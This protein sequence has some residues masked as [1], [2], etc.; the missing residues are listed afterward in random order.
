MIKWLN[1]HSLNFK[2]NITILTCVCIS[3][4][5]LIY[6]IS[7]K[8]ETIILSQINHTAQ[9]TVSSYAEDFEHLVSDT[10]QIIINTKNTLSQMNKNDISALEA[11]LNSA[12][13]TVEYSD[14]NFTEAWVYK[15]PP[16][17]VSSGTIYISKN[18]AEDNA[19]FNTEKISNFYE[20]YPWFKEVP[21]IEKIYWSEPYIDRNT[22]NAV[23]T[24]LIP[25][26]F[27]DET[28]FN[29]LA[30]LTVDLSSIQNSLNSFSAQEPGII[31]LLS[32]LG[33]HLTHPDPDVA[34]KMTIFEVAEKINQ[35]ELKIIGEDMLLSGQSGNIKIPDF[36]IYNGT[37]IIYYA[38]IKSINWG[39]C[40]VYRQDELLQPIRQ[41]QLVMFSGL[42]I[43]ILLLLFI[44]NRICKHSTDQLLSLS[45]LAEKYGCG[46]FSENFNDIPTSS[47][48]SVLAQALSDM[49]TNIL[50]YTEKERQ[51]AA[52]KQKSQSELEIA[53]NIQTASLSQNYPQ[54]EAFKIST[55]II[56]ARE[57]GGDFYDFFFIDKNHFAIVIA[58]VSGKGIPAALYMMKSQTLIKNISKSQTDLAKVFHQVNNE[59]CEGNN[60][61]MFVTVFMAIIDLQNGNV[62]YANAGHTPPMLKTDKGYDFMTPHKNI[63][64][65]I[66]KDAEFMIETL[67][68]KPDNH[69]FL[70]TDGVTEA[71]NAKAKFYGPERL[72][73]VLQKASDDPETNLNLVLKDIKKFVKDNTQSDDITMLDFA[74]LGCSEG[75]LNLPADN[76][77]LH[78][79]IDFL[80]SDMNKHNVPEKKQFNLISAAEEIFAN[81]A[82]YAYE[83]KGNVKIT[84]YVKDET[85]YASFSDNGKKYNPLKNKD[86]DI[87]CELKDRKIGGLGI[88]LAK[89]LSD[90]ISYSY[91]KG[92]NI[93][94]IGVNLNH[95]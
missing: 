32:R 17:D 44:I 63:I 61:C 7:Q 82:G 41:F 30:A 68:L 28:D 64:L 9:K 11:V 42:I 89:K 43:G 60:T 2:L 53:R 34:L 36:S 13:R 67:K 49:R 50:D 18:I 24:C 71:E 55:K 83:E 58:D 57:V 46:D 84:T 77:Q 73:K 23:V 51:D 15:F 20:F 94:T 3:F 22:Q 93:L 40:L 91:K 92:Q 62:Q 70:Y 74:Y 72:K 35:P 10:E 75:Y 87:T 90:E 19:Q 95:L 39:I 86:P 8:A 76:K 33:L 27:K 4:F 26:K 81:I 31:F 69:I 65:G 79:L 80:K 78:K 56:P 14:L 6:F 85:Y 45:N 88:F 59:L 66:K 54:H 47:D 52:D 12:I 38:P 21:K 29:G 1:K 48:I 25:F 5:A 37:A 16:E